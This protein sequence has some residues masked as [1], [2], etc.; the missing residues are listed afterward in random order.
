[1]DWDQPRPPVS[2]LLMTQ[3]AVEHGATADDCLIG[4]GLTADLLLDP[5][6][7]VTPRHDLAVA[8]NLLSIVPSG[9]PGVEMGSRFRLTEQG[10]F[11][12][13]LLSSP[14]LR[15]AVDVG[16]RFLDLAF[17]MGTVVAREADTGDLILSLDAPELPP[18]M[19]RFYVERDAASIV[20]IQRGLAPTLDAIT[21]IEFAFPEPTDGVDIYR[22]TLGVVPTFDAPESVLVVDRAYLDSPLP[23]ANPHTAAHAIE[24]CRQLLDSRRTRTG[25]AGK[26]RDEL[27]AGIADPPPLDS[28]ATTL[29]MSG[30]TLRKHLTAEG[31]SYR[32][33]LDEV[34]EHL[35][36]E[37]LLTGQ[38]PVETIA[39]R[40]GYVEVSSFSQAF[41]R[42]K[43]VGPREFRTRFRA[44]QRSLSDARP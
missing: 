7:E 41:R 19:R 36:E 2:L 10:I 35:A 15:A 12:F 22:E 44:G 14:T 20:T 42:W 28:V 31:T 8:R 32:L 17:A 21:R 30:R 5:Q 18:T 13:A 40:L 27:L 16:L 39:H 9:S 26:V 33:L 37:L 11:G 29:L 23:G 25:V 6:V 34:R 38:L 1:M 43:G 4:T 3:I 24:Q